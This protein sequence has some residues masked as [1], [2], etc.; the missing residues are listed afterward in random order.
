MEI[1]ELEKK[2]PKPSKTLSRAAVMPGKVF[3]VRW[4]EVNRKAGAALLAERLHGDGVRVR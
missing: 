4:L 1:A 3:T 2:H